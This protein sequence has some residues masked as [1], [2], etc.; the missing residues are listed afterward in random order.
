MLD[1]IGRDLRFAARGLWRSPGFT[2]ITVATLALGIGANTAIFSVVNAVLLR[3]LAYRDPAQLVALK[4]VVEVRGLDDVR[5][6]APEYQDFRS[7]VPALADVAAAWPIS[8]NLTALGDP[9]RIQ[10]AV[11]SSN[12]FQVLG[13]APTLGRDFTPEDDQG[14]IGYVA[15]ISWDL[16]Q[17]RFGGDRSVI[18]KTVRLDDDPM[19]IIGVMPR[20]FRHPLESGASPMEVWA[21]VELANAD[22]QFI[23]DRRARVFEVIGRLKPGATVSEAQAQLD[24]LSKQ[25]ESRYP[26]VYPAALGWRAAALPLTERVV[27]NVRPAL[28]VLLGAV[29]FVLLIGCANVANLMLARATGRSREIAIRTALGGDR[30]RLVRQLLTESL[31][32]AVLGG[33]LGLLIAVWGTSALG[34]LAAVYLPRAREI[35]IDGPVLA[36]TAV[37]ILLTGVAFGLF[38]AL[39]ASRPDLQDVLKD[40]AKGSAGGGRT[41]MRAVLVVAEVAVAL[42]LLA[43]AG[44]LLRSFQ[45]LVA[46][47][48]GFDPERL[49]TMQVWLPV[50]NDNAT[51]RYF[52]QDQRVGFYDRALA[53]VRQV[54]GVRS[55]SLVSRLPYSG[56]NDARF[57]I[58]GRPVADAQ[59]LPSAEIRLVSPGYFRTMAI[60]V[61]QG[62]VMPDGVDSLSSTYAMVNRSLAEREWKG[63]SPVGQRI[64][65]QLPGSAGPWVTIVGVVNDVRQGAPDQPTLP[66]FYVSYRLLAGQQMSLVVR[67]AGDPD[68]L[69]ARVVSAIRSVDPTQP[70]FGV[71]SMERLLAN[72]EAERRFS[73]LLLSLFAAIAL[74]LSSLGIY[75]VMAYS[76][77]QRRHEIGIRMA[78][79]AASPDVL[80]LVLSQG[81]RLVLVGLAIGLFGAWALSRVLAGQL[82]GISARDPLTYAA[83]ATLLGAVAFAATWLPARRATRVDPMISLRSE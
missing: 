68:A 69:A 80:R 40:S 27:G 2:A 65:L 9:E 54:P 46:V 19:T 58:E 16:F 26:D 62:E 6:S 70:V 13:T 1:T 72:A 56:R 20:G 28:L 42:V 17:R 22:P 47:D 44:L 12:Y 78:L 64:Q 30:L 31:L 29:A 73:L 59:L 81:M 7:D 23:G 35:A 60:P 41:R 45:Q 61:L 71:E 3:P 25:L 51:G 66:E 52:T 15:I 63:R 37:L 5:N 33:A 50:P 48:P 10:A 43:G 55:A 11:V 75:G 38:P 67:T 39:Q 74:L 77:S 79:G 24:Q 49:L 32:L 53:A 8:I 4:G 18:G 57:R 21:P 36:F 34:R 83:V 14:K 82:Y 76:T